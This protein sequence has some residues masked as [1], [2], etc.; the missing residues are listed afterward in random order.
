MSGSL[1]IQLTIGCALLAMCTSVRAGGCAPYRC[2]GVVV[3]EME[4]RG[5][6]SAI[7]VSFDENPSALSCDASGNTGFVYARIE[8]SQTGYANLKD[9]VNLAAALG[10]SSVVSFE[11]IPGQPCRIQR[12]Q[13]TY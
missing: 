4:S 5:D 3:T 9:Q 1:F 2:I 6:S 8:T 7:F 10:L 12:L 13:V 11:E